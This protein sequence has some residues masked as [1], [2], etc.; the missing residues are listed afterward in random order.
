MKKI[1][2][3]EDNPDNADLV[4][5]FLDDL[6]DIHA[7]VDGFSGLEVLRNNSFDPDLILCDI[8]LPGMDGVQFLTE[9]RQL[10]AHAHKPIIALTSH[11]MKG[12]QERFLAAGFNAY[13]GK[14]I[15]DDVALIEPIERLL[16]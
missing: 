3:I 16:K 12:D 15:L 6:Y 4:F 13:V 10:P 2:L 1:L 8:S 11:A 7:C 14:P 5:A 9:M